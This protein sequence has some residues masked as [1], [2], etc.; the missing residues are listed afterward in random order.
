MIFN[1]SMADTIELRSF[2]TNWFERHGIIST[3]E[4]KKFKDAEFFELMQRH[5]AS[6]A[7]VSPLYDAVGVRVGGSEIDDQ[8]INN[9]KLVIFVKNPTI[10]DEILIRKLP[11]S[12][13]IV[14]ST[15][16]SIADADAVTK[17]LL[18]LLDTNPNLMQK[19]AGFYHD[20]K[21]GGFR[22]QTI[23][24]DAAAVQKLLSLDPDLR[25]LSF[26]VEKGQR[27]EPMAK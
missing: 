2:K 4:K 9:P 20:P 11:K 1:S 19:F 18:S 21:G 8:S 15:R 27:A 26:K 14:K 13:A 23:D 12:Q 10:K 25:T 22:F 3:L 16:Y 7:L 6:M 17:K 24:G 5:S